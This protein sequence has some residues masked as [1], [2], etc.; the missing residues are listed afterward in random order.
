M[1]KPILLRTFFALL[2]LTVSAFGDDIA[3]QVAVG[4]NVTLT[5]TADGTPPITY[6]WF[7]N[8]EQIGE[9]ATFVIP[10]FGPSN[11]G[12][13][14][15]RASNAFGTTDGTDRILLTFGLPPSPPRITIALANA[16]VKKGSDV[17]LQV[18]TTGNPAPTYQW[19]HGVTNIR[20]A[21][22]P[23][24]VLRDLKPKDGGTYAVRATN[25]NGWV[26]SGMKL[27]VPVR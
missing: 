8:S 11:E 15:V 23:T 24:L 19:R 10:S 2:A 4:Q 12:A 21:T 5:A 7:R 17:T 13:Y 26:E 22:Q 20:G 18:A 25:A 6:K 1:R 27:T 9:G 3:R 14:T 16:V